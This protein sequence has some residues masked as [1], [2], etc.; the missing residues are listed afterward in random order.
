MQGSDRS[1]AGLLV[2][3]GPAPDRA[4]KMALYGWLVGAW[5]MDAVVHMDDG[6][7]HTGQ[8]EI[9]FAWA[10]QGRAIVDVW[11]LPGVFYGT[12]LRV[13]D[14]GIDAWHIIWSDPVRQ[15]YA[16]QIGRAQGADIVQ[17]GKTDA[18][19]AIRWRF[20]DITPDSFRWLGERSLDD[21]NTWQLQ[22]EFLAR[23][24]ST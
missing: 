17:L 5:T 19:D 13:Y 7:R 4:E 11:V 9:R 20:T 10:L 23:R 22:A 2:A 1:L 15:Y 14:P 12:T 16:R 3:D 6:G 18:G 21:G 8:G 24:T